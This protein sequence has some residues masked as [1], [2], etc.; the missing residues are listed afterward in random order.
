M[1]SNQNSFFNTSAYKQKNFQTV[2]L[3]WKANIF[4]SDNGGLTLFCFLK[5]MCVL[6]HQESDFQSSFYALESLK[7]VPTNCTK[8]VTNKRQNQLSEE[9]SGSDGTKPQCK[10]VKTDI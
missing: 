3:Y 5:T 7:D 6:G 9:V 2:S 8:V 1:T 10:H 4:I